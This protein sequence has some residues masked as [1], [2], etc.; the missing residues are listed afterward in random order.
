MTLPLALLLARVVVVAALLSAVG[1]LVFGVA[2]APKAL[3]K[4]PA[5][6]AA[7]ITGRLKA[8]S[9]FSLAVALA[10]MVG[11][12]LLQSA[13]FAQ[14]S[15]IAGALA[16]VPD[17]LAA[18]RFG[19]FAVAGIAACA[20]ALLALRW[21]GGV[22]SWRL[23][24]SFATLATALHAGHLHAFAMQGLS[25]L[26]A[27]EVVHLLAAGV[28]LGGLLPL[29][30]VVA[31][32]PPA[33]GAA[34]ARWFSPL[35]K[36]CVVATALS[37]AWQGWA[38]VGSVPGLIGTPYGRTALVKLSLL[39]VLLGFAWA[40]RYRLA[41]ALR[42]GHPDAARRR[43][44]VSV[45][46]QTA[47][48]LLTV[49]AAV[50]LSSLSPAIHEQPYWPFSVRPSLV[51]LAEPELRQE[52]TAALM[53]GALGA[54]LMVRALWWRRWRWPA[55]ALAAG[56]TALA[57]PHLDLLFVP[58]YPTSF[59][60]SPTGFAAASIVAGAAL[61]PEACASCHGD[62]G[63]GDGRQAASLAVPPADLTALHLWEHPDGELFWWLSHGMDAPAGGQSMPGFADRL[64]PDERWALIDFI[65]ARNAG[66]AFAR[67]G[68]WPVALRAPGFDSLCP[69][70]H[71]LALRD[72]SGSVVRLTIAAAGL[73]EIAPVAQDG[74]EGVGCLAPDAGIAGA[75]AV[76][77]GLTPDALQGSVF[78]IDAEGWLRQWLPP[79]TDM[80]AAA[81]ELR[82]ICIH[83]LAPAEGGAH[84]HSH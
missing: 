73:V 64:S 66:T 49:L 11:W 4:A 17:V 20:L 26:L 83:P 42:G 34:A 44:L 15:D 50:E 21:P 37:A 18:T 45:A 57:A 36:A 54:V 9:R 24:M 82:D 30:L 84:S 71:V 43:L 7:R 51:A 80:R 55:L 10:S 3:A 16:A 59:Y 47:V 62:Q 12:M 27:V 74:T 78:L 60:R 77:A 5:H 75:Y 31:A 39:G 32:S 81:R 35:G 28:W 23:A 52:V 38:L 29:L 65:R 48:G 68:T 14:A 67:D 46:L 53:A 79:G 70:G 72:L 25:P 58:A 41:P 22:P 76:V 19:Q 1:T 8:L 61:Y 6:L 56:C 63:R 13:A 40:N 33:I 69:D 2:V